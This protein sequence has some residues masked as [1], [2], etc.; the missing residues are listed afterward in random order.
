MAVIAAALETRGRSTNTDCSHLVHEVYER[1]GFSY[2]YIPSSEIYLGSEGFRRVTHP[3][4]G[5]LVVWPGHVGI[6]V[7][8]AQHSFF[9]ALNSGLGVDSYDSTYWK[10]RGRPRFFRFV[11][12][13]SSPNRVANRNVPGLKNT[14]LQT[15]AGAAPLEATPQEVSR[16]VPEVEERIPAEVVVPRILVETAKPA[17]EQ[18]S[19]ALLQAMDKTGDALRGQDIFQ[20]K[21]DLTV[22]GGFQVRQVKIKSDRGSAEVEM[23]EPASVNTG[24]LNLKTRRAKQ[25]WI[26]IRIAP[27]KWEL[28]PPQPNLY[29]K[30]DDAVQVFAHQLAEM[31]DSG[32]SSQEVARKAQLAQLLQAL[33]PAKN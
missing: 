14:V 15:N 5:D 3:Q 24:Q 30:H 29:L 27:D 19:A 26:L 21:R 28:L 32:G 25:R 17:P 31:T 8:P 13:A 4:P 18:I 33:L 10:E 6:L 7:S 16:T 2:D 1:A 23:E 22:V 9:S 11:K 12:Q 20:L